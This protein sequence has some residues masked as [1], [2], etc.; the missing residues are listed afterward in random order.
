MRRGLLLLFVPA[1][2]WAEGEKNAKD[3]PKPKRPGDI[4]IARPGTPIEDS[5]VARHEVR[6]FHKGMS[7]A[8][9]GQRRVELIQRLGNYNH[10]EILR[11][12]SKYLKDKSHPVAVAAVVAC[13]RQGR[14]KDKAGA[15][16]MKRLKKEKRP[17]VV[18]ALL[19]GMG[20]LGYEHKGVVKEAKK[21]H[22][23][24]TKQTHKAAA[25]YYGHIKY[26]PAFRALA[27]HL[28]EPMAKNPDDPNN[29][30][31]AWWKERWTEWDANVKYTRWALA[32][33]VPGET[34]DSTEEAKR[35]ALTEGKEHGIEW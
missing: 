21:Y 2:L 5:S 10:P 13:A 20:V 14:A 4:E 15:A 25:R 33:L 24:D 1:L 3:K 30:P 32:Q 26:K 23:R 16:L 11:A 17:H 29:P 18:C 27:E 8:E 12:A 31:A 7:K 35:W 28:D 22:R 34:F 6:L 9:S 19:I